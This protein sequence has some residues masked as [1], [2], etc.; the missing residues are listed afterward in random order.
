MVP[1]WVTI[2][3]MI[4]CNGV[5]VPSGRVWNPWRGRRDPSG[6]LGL[7]PLEIEEARILDGN[8]SQVRHPVSVRV[9]P[10]QMV[11]V[12]RPNP[13]SLSMRSA[14]Y[15]RP[16]GPILSD[17][18]ESGCLPCRRL[19]ERAGQDRFAGSA[20]EIDLEQAQVVEQLEIGGPPS[21]ASLQ[22]G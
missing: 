20:A 7:R 15:T 8:N 5:S 17:P 1:S 10:H 6:F 2:I 19:P 22:S 18:R 3:A 14:E 13:V 16:S 9:E 21:A 12:S 11:K 4:T